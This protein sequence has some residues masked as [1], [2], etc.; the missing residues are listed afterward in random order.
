MGCHPLAGRA[1]AGAG[2]HLTQP[3]GGR[4]AGL[5]GAFLVAAGTAALAVPAFFA[6]RTAD[7]PA[8]PAR[9]DTR[10]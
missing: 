7:G 10:A 9:P 6:V 1:P 8:R 5:P 4:A 2:A 3:D